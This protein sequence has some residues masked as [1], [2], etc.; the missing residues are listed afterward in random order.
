MVVVEGKA[1]HRI[2]EY[3][4]GEAFPMAV[5]PWEKRLVLLNF[6]LENKEEARKVH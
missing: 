5:F 2:R 6:F 4:Q 3:N 1:S